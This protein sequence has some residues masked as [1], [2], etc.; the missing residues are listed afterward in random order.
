MADDGQ[1]LPDYYALLGIGF[2]AS[3]DELRRAWREA[4]KRWHPDTNR[5][6]DAHR[7]MASVNEAWEVLGNAQRR[8]EY[9]S[10]YFRMRAD[11]ADAERK[12][13]EAE[14]QEWER[15]ERLRQ[16][17][18]ERKRREAEAARQ[19]AEAEARRRAERD[20]QERARQE[21][22]R[23][24]RERQQREARQRAEAERRRRADR[25]REHLHQQQERAREEAESRQRAAQDRDGRDRERRDRAR[26]RA[27]EGHRTGGE[28]GRRQ[29]WWHI[30]YPDVFRKVPFWV[31]AVAGIALSAVMGLI[32]AGF[33]VIFAQQDGNGNDQDDS[34]MV[35]T[36]GWGTILA[37]GNGSP[38]CSATASGVRNVAAY[39]E[40]PQAEAW[41]LTPDASEWSAGFL[42]HSST[43]GY[44][45]AA[46]RR[47]AGQYE[48]VSW[49]QTRSSEVA[50]SA[51]AIRPDL[52]HPV[53]SKVPNTFRMEVSDGD[54]ALV[55]NDVLL[56]R[57]PSGDF[58]PIESSV[59]FCAGFFSGEPAYTVEF[60]G[61]RGTI[62]DDSSFRGVV[63]RRQHWPPL[64]ASTEPTPGDGGS[65][66]SVIAG[67]GRFFAHPRQSIDCSTDVVAFGETFVAEADFSVPPG[68]AW[69]VGFVYH[70]S[71]S[72]FSAA[73]IRR[74]A[75]TLDAIA[76]TDA[77]SGT[78]AQYKIPI[79]LDLVRPADS[80]TPNVIRIESAETGTKLVLNNSELLHVDPIDTRPYA[81]DARL[82]AGFWDD[83]PGYAIAYSQ[84]RGSDSETITSPET[85][86]PVV[87]LADTPE[88]T[89]RPT[90][91]PT[92]TATPPPTARAT[93]TPWPTPT[94][95][96]TATP[97]PTPTPTPVPLPTAT[98]SPT[99]SPTPVPLPTAT[100][101]PTPFISWV[102]TATPT[103]TPSPTPTHTATPSPTRTPTPSPTI[104]PSPTATPTPIP[105]PWTVRIERYLLTPTPSIGSWIDS[106]LD[107]TPETATAQS[108]PSFQTFS[109]DSGT[110][111]A[112]ATS[113]RI[114]CPRNNN[115]AAFLSSRAKSASV[116]FGFEVPRASRWSIGL[117]YHRW[118]SNDTDAATFL[119]K[120]SGGEYRAGHWTRF[121]GENTHYVESEAI[122]SSVFSGSV[123]AD[124]TIAIRT[125]ED[126]SVLE[127]N[128]TIMLRVPASELRPTSNQM[129][130]CAGLLRGETERYSIDYYRLIAWT[131]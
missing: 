85:T 3:D 71:E 32:A 122:P 81:S 87:R 100:P 43:S 33:V 62:S 90:A 11:M 7:M 128:G 29:F 25:D 124:N 63:N 57:M 114:G 27:R 46:V 12:R 72:V 68:N 95:I 61:L 126:G 76:W 107:G 47:T 6:P 99:P 103:P 104:T 26:Q 101:T 67:A 116:V 55:V 70:V 54:T 45:V 91:A 78:V 34:V 86:Q 113:G 123:G 30:R 74:R 14:R 40:Y 79:D 92:P 41:F 22:A 31:G 108:V 73:S 4:V 56:A 131:E 105:T 48:L 21:R 17:E 88:P 125:G 9:D 37:S 117:L 69:S 106:I 121:K 35:Q 51:T 44:S 42:Y 18:M 50:R 66:L 8:A 58:R 52:L 38:G 118:S 53:N 120:T 49:T 96:P 24:E 10:H 98:L 59:H 75:A 115:E 129:R 119:F 19:R 111:Y 127:L 1:Q 5:S 36:A 83:E 60:V 97:R 102:H 13:Q 109:R 94:P 28:S 39:G 84:L 77:D 80:F 16:Q 64:P 2:D 15:R 89:A 23:R 93:A 82:C 112:D 65:M 130:V 20:R 110:L